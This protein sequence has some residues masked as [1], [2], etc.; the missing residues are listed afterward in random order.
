VKK[1]NFIG[2]NIKENK[3][4]GQRLAKGGLEAEEWGST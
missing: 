3:I 1:N 4:V 2:F